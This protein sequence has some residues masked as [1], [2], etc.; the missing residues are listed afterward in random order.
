MDHPIWAN[1]SAAEQLEIKKVQP[2]K[3]E[4]KNCF[5]NLH[6]H[7]DLKYVLCLCE[8]CETRQ[9]EHFERVNGKIKK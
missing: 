8:L 1:Q 2:E 7:V 4:C 5:M 9:E 6:C 3:W